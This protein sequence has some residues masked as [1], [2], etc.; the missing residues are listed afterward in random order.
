MDSELD[1]LEKNHT[2]EA[3]NLPSGHKPINSKW[4]Y[5]IKYHPDGTIEKLKARLVVKG[6]S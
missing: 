6:Y 5:K 4:V 1:A 3:T 2:W